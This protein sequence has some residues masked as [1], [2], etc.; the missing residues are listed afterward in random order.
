MDK[1]AWQ[2]HGVPKELDMTEQLTLSL[3]FSVYLKVFFIDL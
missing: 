2:V 1:G 3:H